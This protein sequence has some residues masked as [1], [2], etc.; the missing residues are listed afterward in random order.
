V[1]LGAAAAM[2]APLGGRAYASPP[3]PDEQGTEQTN[4]PP[5]NANPPTHAGQPPGEGGQACGLVPLLDQALSKV[6]LKPDQA[7]QVRALTSE[8]SDKMD[9]LDRA[10]MDF[11]SA[12]ADAIQNGNVDERS[13]QP[14]EHK[15]I[16]AAVQAS[17]VV[18]KDLD[19]LHHALDKK[20]R[21]QFVK[22]LADEINAQT[23]Q[24]KP[25]VKLDKM[26]QELNLSDEQKEKIQKIMS[27]YRIDED[28]QLAR[29]NFVL[30]AFLSKHFKMDDLVPRN[31]ARD[32]TDHTLDDII[33]GV[34]RV[35]DVLTPEQRAK[36]ADMI[37]SYTSGQG[38]GTSGGA[39]SEPENAGQTG[40]ST[41]S[42]G[43]CMPQADFD[44]L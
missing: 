19:Q 13:L 5:T 8:L 26:A 31:A 39:G 27:D 20:Q 9:A 11:W 7:D 16:D 34:Q 3:Q 12:L 32:C 33:E 4:N 2:A 25:Q 41:E 1:V 40:S 42:S 29:I 37:R 24:S 43:S 15:V 21:K 23:Q 14:Q 22:A 28:V 30:T 18:R 10:K 44:V 36:M 35:T 38:Q 6:D 17:P